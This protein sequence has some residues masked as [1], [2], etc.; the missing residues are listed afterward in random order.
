MTWAV[1]FEVTPLPGR[2]QRYFDIAAALKPVLERVD[3]F[4]SVERFQSLSRPGVYLSLSY[5][6]DEQA[7]A[8]WRNEAC[9]RGGQR[10]GRDAVF[11]DYRIHVMS[12]VRAYGMRDRSQVPA[13][14]SAAL[15]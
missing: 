14:S 10:E 1:I 12:S 5:W 7:I 15:L 2:E 3:G 8:C 13:D 4:I 6:R 11:A 9:H